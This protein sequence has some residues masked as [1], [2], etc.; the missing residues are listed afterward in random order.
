MTNGILT[1]AQIDALT[2]AQRRELI[3]RLER[4]VAQLKPRNYV[5]RLRQAHLGLMTGGALFMI[6]W[7]V[8]LALTLPPNYTV[9]DWPVTWVGF[10]ILLVTFMAATAILTWQHRQVVVLPAFTTGILP[11][12]DA[13]FDVTTAGDADFA[14]TL[15]TAFLG[16][17]LAAVLIVGSVSLVRYN[18]ARLW[19]IDPDQSVWRL[20]LE[21]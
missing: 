20:P 13:W 17:L 10:D 11:V 18:A 3:R 12:C 8:Y 7:I 21:T 4:P 2:G 5:E 16:C 1:D 6:P 15:L 19:L 9:H 14:V